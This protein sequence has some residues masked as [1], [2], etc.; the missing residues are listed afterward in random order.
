MYAYK[1][2]KKEKY[3]KQKKT[4]ERKKERERE[5]ENKQ[6]LIYKLQISAALAHMRLLYLNYSK[7]CKNIYNIS[8]IQL[9]MEINDNQW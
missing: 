9:Q 7:Y 5:K 8:I 6:I 3:T 2:K 4:W 1:Q